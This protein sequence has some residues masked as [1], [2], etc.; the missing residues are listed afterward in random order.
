MKVNE[1][2]KKIFAMS[3][4]F[5]IVMF[6]KMF[7]YKIFFKK[8]YV[9]MVITYLSEE[10][11]DIIDKY[12]SLEH[13]I[14]TSNLKSNIKEPIWICWWQGEENCPEIIQCCI[15]SVR[16]NSNGHEVILINKENYNKYIKMPDYI[17]DKLN[18]N[19]ITITHFSDLLRVSLLDEY[20]G[21]WVDA[22]LYLSGEISYDIFKKEFFTRKITNYVG[23]NVAQGRWSAYLF[24]GAPNCILFSFLREVFLKYWENNNIL[25]NYFF[26]DFSIEIAYKNISEIKKLIDNNAPNNPQ[27]HELALKLNDTYNEEALKEITKDTIFHKLTYKKEFNL[28]TKD[29]KKTFYNIILNK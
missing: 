2:L 14:Q 18:R 29:N 20:G 13:P 21:L 26:I 28:F 19:M 11:K 5:G 22:S 7:F 24:G 23:E 1:S 16:K 12:K 25:I 15:N 10:F 6:S 3:K 8:K 9:D 17:L 27:I 4:N